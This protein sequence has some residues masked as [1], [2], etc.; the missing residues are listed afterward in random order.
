MLNYWHSIKKTQHLLFRSD[1]SSTGQKHKFQ[2]EDSAVA[3][4]EGVDW[5]VDTLKQK[6][7]RGPGNVPAHS[8]CQPGF[9][10]QKNADE[11]EESKVILAC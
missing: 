5:T 8:D 4:N 3:R 7:L 9:V 6:I 11:T 1:C 2:A 10:R